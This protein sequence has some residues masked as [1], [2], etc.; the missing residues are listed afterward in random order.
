[1]ATRS[2]R[3]HS[4]P[5]TDLVNIQEVINEWS[6]LL[7]STDGRRP[8]PRARSKCTKL[9]FFLLLLLFLLTIAI[10][11]ALGVT[12]SARSEQSGGCS[13][14][15]YRFD[16]YTEG[17]GNEAACSSRGCC[18]NSLVSPSCFYP[19]GFG[20]SMNGALSIERYGHSLSRKANQPIQYTGPV[21][22]LR[23]DV[24]L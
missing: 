7:A 12:L 2:Y 15:T 19:D 22:K 14:A 6:S 18:W 1:M 11:V 4:S 10:S 16:C 21:A 9:V 24:Y 13:A 3:L 23:V 17:D 5:F 20:Y 8:R